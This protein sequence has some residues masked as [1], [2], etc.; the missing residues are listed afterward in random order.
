MPNPSSSQHDYSSL[1]IPTYEEAITTS[2]SRTGPSEISDD[3]ERQGLLGNTNYEPPSVES[4]RSSLDSLDGLAD[5]HPERSRRDMQQMDIEDPLSDTPS[6][7]S[8]LRNRLAKNFSWTS[9]LSSLTLPSFR[10]WLRFPRF[11][12]PQLNYDSISAHR[13]IILG[14]LFGIFLIMG[15]VY[16]LIATDILAFG[17]GRL[18]VGQMYDPESIRIFVQKHVNQRE[19]MQEYLTYVTEFPHMAGSE[20][21]YIVGEWIQEIFKTADME[22]VDMERFDVFMNYPRRDGRSVSIIEPPAAKWDAYVAEEGG[23][24]AVFHGHSASGRVNGHIIYANYGSRD[25]FAKLKDEGID[26][27]GAVV[28]MR[29]YGTQRDAGLKVKAAEMAG[30]VGALLYTDPQGN[31]PPQGDELRRYGR[32]LPDDGVQRDSVSFQ[33]WVMGDVL[34][35]GW[36]STPGSKQGD[37]PANSA[38]LPQIPSLPISWKDAKH[39]L[40]QI[41]G[42]GTK[43]NGD[44]SGD[45][46]LEYWTGSRNSPTVELRNE[47]DTEIHQPIYNVVG[48]V[49]GWEEPDK[50]VVVGVPRDAWCRGA[51]VPGTGIAV[52]LEV[53][54]IFGE[55]RNLHWR[56]LRT[57]EFVSWDA[58]TFNLE[59]S[60]EHVENRVQ[61]LRENGIAYVNLAGVI[62]HDFFAQGSPA[63]KRVVADALSRI[64]DPESLDSE[65]AKSLK[66]AWDE[67]EQGGQIELPGLRGDYAPFANIAGVPTLNI[68]FGNRDRRDIGG[69]CYD[70]RDHVSAEV[71]ILFEHQRTLGEVLALVILELADKPVMPHDL[72]AYVEKLQIEKDHLVDWLKDQPSEARDVDLKPLQDAIELVRSGASEVH[73]VEAHWVRHVFSHGGFEGNRF[74]NMRLDVNKRLAGFEKDL[75]DVRDMLVSE[76]YTGKAVD[77]GKGGLKGRSAQFKAVVFAPSLWDT[78]KG[79]GF[80]DVRRAVEDEGS[81]KEA[82]LAV[83]VVAD[84]LR[85]AAQGLRGVG[86]VE[87][88]EGDE[89]GGG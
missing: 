83:Q 76:T 69:S 24:T 58:S 72:N 17:S 11:S 64:R 31:L 27:K 87:G 14:R 32:Y 34:S 36:P 5:D 55:L 77:S 73:G 2:A 18:N 40:T 26:V 61:E 53:V 86:T 71:D 8:L 85:D 37:K 88:D 7:R 19:R 84:R 43:G 59:G 67:G 16:A 51:S 20:G 68:G 28:L 33:S 50:R 10:S 4:A 30:A 12:F 35:P 42:L 65:E 45:Q 41:K 74:V 54:R 81:L 79:V 23:D 57:I 29:N 1:P 80:P 82:Q 22:D 9:S 13:A 44:W 89:G 49:T 48:H 60:T 66:Q 75:L 38:G 78:S 70:D 47:Q 3:A 63:M 25:D 21:S 39:L 52:M 15:V 46:D 56:P 62:G 6:N